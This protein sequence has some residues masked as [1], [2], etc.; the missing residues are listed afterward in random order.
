MAS[1]NVSEDDFVIIASAALMAK[2][3]GD[4]N[5]AAALDKIAR[6]INASLTGANPLRKSIAFTGLR[7]VVRWQDMPSVLEPLETQNDL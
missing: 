1:I 4:M 7:S 6:K 2:D 5:V 3:R